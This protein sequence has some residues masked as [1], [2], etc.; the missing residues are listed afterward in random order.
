MQRKG[1]YPPEGSDKPANLASNYQSTQPQ[2]DAK[3]PSWMRRSIWALGFGTTAIASAIVGLALSLTLPLPERLVSGETAQ[4]PSL[5][6]L[7]KKGVR[8]RITRPV[9]I[10]VMGIDEV[11]EAEENTDEVFAGR[12]DTMILAQVNPDTQLV[13][14]LS[15]PRDTQVEFPDRR[16]VSKINHANWIGGPRLAADVVSYNLGNVTVD[17]Y[18]RFS[19]DAFKELVDLL[20]G[21]E[22]FVPKPMKYEDQTQ[23]LF[24]DLDQ[25]LQVLNGEEAEQFARF[26][27]DEYGDI[28][29]VQRQQV[30]IRALRDRLTNPSVIAKIPQI[31]E[32]LQTKID[33]NLT[34]QEMLALA[35]FSLDVNRDDLRMVMLP[36]RFSRQQEYTASYWLMEPSSVERVMEDYF[37]VNSVTYA[38]NAV[39]N[40]GPS[41]R[42]LRIAVQNASS[43]PQ[44]ASE[45]A[46]YLRERG[47]SNVY[48]VRDWPEQNIQTNVIVQRGDLSGAARLENVL[49]LG[50]IV[51]SS[52]GDLGSDFTIRVGNDW[53]Q[54]PD[55]EL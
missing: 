1:A 18:V 7:L 9:N 49:G 46:Q 22:V 45:V 3:Q 28:G 26:R 40:D 51:P 44:V 39:V 21:V 48:I 33:T 31:L 30:L 4:P 12:S 53:L 38:S 27:N 14:L 24:I 16:Q 23:K 20:G 37:G 52:T 55:L 17:R 8:H 11:L 10:L 34:P 19:T 42:D 5:P 2:S 25:G 50:E 35:T 15:I 6:E 29:R 47:F 36:G 41:F 43:D 32:L 54:E 13:S